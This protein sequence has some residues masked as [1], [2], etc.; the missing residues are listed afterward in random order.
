[1]LE[2]Y[3]FSV[4]QVRYIKAA[5][6]QVPSFRP[7][8]LSTTDVA[9]MTPNP[10]PTRGNYITKQ[11]AAG[12]ARDA[13]NNGATSVHDVGTDFLA[14]ARSVYRKNPSVQEQLD[15]IMTKDQT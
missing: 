11:T 6:D 13:R 8:G 7:D 14:Q 12:V 4:T 9:A 1:M 2:M 3:D 5:M 15:R 10:D